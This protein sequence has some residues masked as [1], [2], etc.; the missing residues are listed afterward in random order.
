MWSFIN[1]TFLSGQEQGTESYFSC[2][3]HRDDVAL[4]HPMNR[5]EGFINRHP[6]LGFNRTERWQINLDIGRKRWIEHLSVSLF[7]P[8]DGEI[9][10]FSAVNCSNTIL[11]CFFVYPITFSAWGVLI[12]LY[13]TIDFELRWSF[14]T[15]L[16]WKLWLKHFG[17]CSPCIFQN[18]QRFQVL[19][20]FFK[21][22]VRCV[23]F[24]SRLFLSL[25][26]CK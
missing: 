15:D 21:T 3:I 10:D 14:H 2:I 19:R 1:S 25:S 20:F 4:N 5:L 6:G 12:L 18:P 23:S 8:I 9:A 7:L 24:V 13:R 22:R 16:V 11:Y 17:L 26:F